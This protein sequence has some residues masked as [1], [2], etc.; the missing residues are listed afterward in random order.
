MSTE[1]RHGP[2]MTVNGT[3]YVNLG[4][5]NGGIILDISE[6]GLSFESRAP[7]E[8]TGSIRL[9]F[10]H[11]SRR[12]ETDVDQLCKD[13]EHITGVSRLIEVE[14]ELLWRDDTRKRGG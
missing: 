3:A 14:S 2:R 10:S 12:I 9:W 11:R 6:G 13:Q 5:D 4:P 8:R 7:V 1:R